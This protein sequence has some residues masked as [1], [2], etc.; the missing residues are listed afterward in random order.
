MAVSVV[1]FSFSRAAQPEAQGPICWGVAF[2]IAS[3]QH[4]LGNPDG[5]WGPE[6]LLIRCSKGSHYP[7]EWALGLR[8]SSPG[9]EKDTTL[10]AIT[11]GSKYFSYV[12]SPAPSHKKTLSNPF[13][14]LAIK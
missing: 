1:S 3:Y 7:A 4:L 5:V 2:F 12:R 13:R 11:L 10:T 6:K 9:D 14:T 8:L